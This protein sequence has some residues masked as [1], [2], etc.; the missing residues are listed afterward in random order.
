[1]TREQQWVVLFLASFLI[2]CFFLTSR[3]SSFLSPPRSVEAE[4]S[5]PKETGEE[6]IQVEVDGS[7]QRR[8]IYPMVKGEDV[9]D[10]L[11]KA[12]GIKGRISLPAAVLR[13]K[14]EKSCRI[15]VSPEGEERGKITVG[16]L[17]PPKLPVLSI[18]IPINTASLEELMT[19]PGIGPK[20]ARAIFEFREQEGK[21]TTPE[22]LL[23]VK[24][25]GPKK[26]AAMRKHITAP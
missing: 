5:A 15:H 26:L 9:F 17:A 8:G 23:R 7:V 16:P 14:I 25:I 1:M 22:D 12:G 11:E 13:S 4:D 19:L 18:P 2:L 20:T 10:A 6:R 21:F 3:P 24:G